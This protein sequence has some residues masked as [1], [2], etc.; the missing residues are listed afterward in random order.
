MN[1]SKSRALVVVSVSVLLTYAIV[2][3]TRNGSVE[4]AHM[5]VISLCAVVAF[6]VQWLVF[7]P[8]YVYQTERFYDLTGS[9]TFV[10][11]SIIALIAAKPISLYEGLLACMIII[12]ACRLGS[13]LF[14][15]ILKDGKDDRFNDI[16]QDKYRFFSAWTLQGLWVFITS[17]SLITAIASHQQVEMGAL[18]YLGIFVWAVGFVIEVV[19]DRQ[20]QVF[21]KETKNQHVFI[22]TGLWKFSRHPN[23][24]GEILIW[25]GAAI[26]SLPAISHWQYVVLISPVF[27]II[28]LTK[29]SG[30]PL[31]EAKADLKWKDNVDYANY[32]AN[33]P[34]LIPFLK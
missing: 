31:L 14:L 22:T 10:C 7:I 1:N 25:L 13:Y 15:R 6:A 21:R 32:K 28:L 30:I 16:K 5:S 27:V 20:K 23:Y 26:A 8:S 11:L 29:V 24:F 4:L 2:S 3:A 18:A 34:V 17:I 12:W 9:V 33:T 19:A